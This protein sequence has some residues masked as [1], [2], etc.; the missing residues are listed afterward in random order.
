MV[1]SPDLFLAFFDHDASAG[2]LV[3][4]QMKANISSETITTKNV[5]PC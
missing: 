2:L 1:T 3:P 5:E 4:I